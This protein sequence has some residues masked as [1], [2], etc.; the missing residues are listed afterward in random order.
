MM[1][2]PTP[3]ER[4]SG[5]NDKVMKY[6]YTFEEVSKI[7]AQVAK[8]EKKASAMEEAAAA[9]EIKSHEF[10]I[11]FKKYDYSF[12]NA[13]EEV[14]TMF[15]EKCHL[16]DE[17]DKA[18]KVYRK[19]AKEFVVMWEMSKDDYEEKVII[20]YSNYNWYHKSF[21]RDIRYWALKASRR[22][23]V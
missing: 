13:P 19:A 14:F 15:A 11:E 10:D 9:Y 6:N 22:I 18:E 4:F 5:Q 17:R 3:P 2:V 23:L 8:I 12:R 1:N 16:E 7:F 20:R 21:V